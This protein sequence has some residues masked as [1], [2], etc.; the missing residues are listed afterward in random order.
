MS[1]WDDTWED[2]ARARKVRKLVDYCR[3]WKIS[4]TEIE[5]LSDRGRS[6]ICDEASVNTASPMTWTEVIGLLAAA[7]LVHK[8]EIVD[9]GLSNYTATCSCGRRWGIATATRERAEASGREHEQAA[10]WRVDPDFDPFAN[11]GGS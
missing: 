10:N 1:G 2:V 9:G 7:D 8:V 3:Q 4:A 11:L 6:Q 5:T